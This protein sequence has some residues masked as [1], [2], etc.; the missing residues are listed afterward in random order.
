MSREDDVVRRLKRSTWQQT[1]TD[2]VLSG[3]NEATIETH[4]WTIEEFI[5]YGLKHGHIERDQ[6][7]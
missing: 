7:E 1:W 3:G 4:G 5:T 2:Y 6:D